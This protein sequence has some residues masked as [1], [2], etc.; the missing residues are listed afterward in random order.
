MKDIQYYKT[1]DIPYPRK[2]DFV[3]FQ[4]NNIVEGSVV[5][6]SLSAGQLKE[7]GFSP[8]SKTQVVT[9]QKIDN[10]EYLVIYR[11]DE[12]GYKEREKA[13]TAKAN[14]LMTEFK[15]DL[16]QSEGYEPESKIAELVY[17]EA[18]DRGH[19][20]GL[21]EVSSYYSSVAE[22]ADSIEQA[23]LESR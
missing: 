7:K 15:R 2:E 16:A 8:V 6:R 17:Q 1:I 14:E 23:V 21:D 11:L 5:H 18:W 22:F 13:Y 19:S 10:V 3:T 12:D 4:V 20:S 9:R